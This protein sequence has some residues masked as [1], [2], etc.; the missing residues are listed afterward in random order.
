M[1]MQAH[2]VDRAIRDDEG[3]NFM[4]AWAGPSSG[5]VFCLSEAPGAEVVQRI[6]QRAGH[7]ADAVDEV[8]VRA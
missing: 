2:N 5:V 6:H 3:V 4:H 7:P 1:L 8:S